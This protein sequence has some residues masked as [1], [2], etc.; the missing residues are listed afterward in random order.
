MRKVSEILKDAREQKK[1]S[2]ED[3]ER[4][5]RIKKAF[6]RAIE[7]GQLHSLPSQSYALG[8]VKNYAKFLGLSES[9]ISAFFRREYEDEGLEVVPEFRRK[10]HKFQKSFFARPQG[11]L[12][13]LA[14][15]SIGFYITFQYGSLLFG[16][17]LSIDN[18]K[19]GQVI[20]ENIIQV[21]G[22][23]DQY[24]T[25]TVDEDEAYVD[26]TGAFKKSIY[27]YSGDKKITVISKNRFGKE[28]KEVISVK[29]E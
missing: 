8:F 15:A 4:A 18:P 5:T 29:V 16:P 19:N 28:T 3:V 27:A 26:V 10:Q 2:L 12:T 9:K 1:L 23:T 17:K 25:V 20:H 22:R 21:K 13:L 6:L 14:F 7:D 11:L 24:A